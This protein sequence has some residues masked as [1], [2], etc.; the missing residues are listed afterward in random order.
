MKKKIKTIFCLND[1]GSTEV[2][3]SLLNLKKNYSNFFFYLRGPALKILDEKF[4]KI[5]KIK[6][7]YD[8]KR[9][10]KIICSSGWSNFNMQIMNYAKN[11]RKY[12]VSIL[13]E[14]S[15]LS[16]RYYHKGNLIKPDEIWS[17]SLTKVNNFFKKRSNVKIKFVKNN[18]RKN[19]YNQ[20]K[21]KKKYNYLLIAT[22]SKVNFYNKLK[23]KF[24]RNKYSYRR[25]IRDINKILEKKKISKLILRKHPMDK[26]KDHEVFFNNFNIDFEVSKNILIENDLKRCRYVLSYSNS[27]K[28]LAKY[29]GNK[30]V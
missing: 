21:K 28:K 17:S 8:L 4:G 6:K 13:D 22:S 29:C 18:F 9:F 2:V 14:E 23:I 27:V 11:N 24:D 3:L 25:I 16:K 10:N 1:A 30:L 15:Y 12:L 26:I 5:K 20:F 19:Y 7:F